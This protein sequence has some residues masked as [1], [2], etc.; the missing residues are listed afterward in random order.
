MSAASRSPFLSSYIW[1]I[2]VCF[3]LFV[4]PLLVYKMK[5]AKSKPVPLGSLSAPMAS[6]LVQPPIEKTVGEKTIEY[7]MYGRV[8]KVNKETTDGIAI[9]F[10]LDADPIQTVLAGFIRPQKNEYELVRY[11]TNFEVKRTV[12]RTSGTELILQALSSARQLEFGLIFPKLGQSS[13]D[14]SLMR[15][16]DGIIRGNWKSL[17]EQRL[18]ISSIGVKAKM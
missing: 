5:I 2:I 11:D 8:T 18:M 9:T 16:L 6:K 7:R 15:D 17:P 14:V 10:V 1:L 13:E 12:E 3:F 4:P